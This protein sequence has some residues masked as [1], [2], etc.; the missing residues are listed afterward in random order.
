MIAAARV[1]DVATASVAL[2]A[3]AD[4][5]GVEVEELAR[6]VVGRT[7]EAGGITGR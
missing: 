7:I 3:N 6:A 4:R 5:T 1:V 2:R